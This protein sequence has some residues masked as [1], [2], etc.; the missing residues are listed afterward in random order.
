MTEL[1]TQ[2]L[3]AFEQL[4][5]QHEKQHNDFVTSYNGLVQ[6]FETTSKENNELRQQVSN[7]S[8]QVESLSAHLQQ[9]EKRY[10][11]NNR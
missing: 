8:R 9:L 7:L 4:Q 10:N 11:K 6:M 3:N 2:L 1:E 5:T